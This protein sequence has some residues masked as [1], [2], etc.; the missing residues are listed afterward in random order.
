MDDDV[1]P[2]RRL[3]SELRRRRVFRVAAVYAVIAWAIIQAMDA[4]L[5]ILEA[6]AWVAQLAVALLAIGLPAALGLAWAFDITSEG[7]RRTTPLQLTASP[8]RPVTQRVLATGLILVSLTAGGWWVAGGDRTTAPRSVAVLPFTN[9]G[10]D[11]AN[12]YLS[13]GITEDILTQLAGLEGLHVTSRTS[14]MQYKGTTKTVREIARELNVDAI[15]EG[16]VRQVDGNLRIVAQLI[17]AGSD[18]HLWAETYDS[19]MED[20]FAVQMDVARKIA[21]ALRV[22]LTHADVVQLE[23]RPSEHPEAYRLYLQGRFAFNRIV[24]S[25]LDAALHHF[26]RATELDPN[27]ADAYAAIAQVYVW[28]SIVAQRDPASTYQPAIA[29]ARRAIELDPMSIEAHV[30]TAALKIGY[31]WDW[32]GADESLE[33][34]LEISPGQQ[35]AL[36]WKALSLIFR[37]RTA[38]AVAVARSSVAADSTNAEGY[39]ALGQVLALAGDGGAAAAELERALEINPSLPAASYWLMY[40]HALNGRLDLADAAYRRARDLG[41]PVPLWEATRASLFAGAGQPG[42]ART[43]LA[44]L[45]RRE[46]AGEY[47]PPYAFFTLHASLGEMDAAMRELHRAVEERSPNLIYLR[48]YRLRPLRADPRFVDALR[49][50]FPGEF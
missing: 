24:L 36:T 25:D 34:A 43:A 45:R 46:A 21:G 27:F 29:A 40:A 30:A 14:V 11:P 10:G 35:Q 5:P 47:V 2:I 33:R 20:I 26:T 44:A 28:M 41:E 3:L 18:R 13:D 39:Q 16:S 19:G 7:V 48:I 4:L 32:A 38:E 50:V 15:L 8:A 1:S 23:R 6:P 31:E 49:A 42:E 37:E 22:R 17:E 12:E 9:M